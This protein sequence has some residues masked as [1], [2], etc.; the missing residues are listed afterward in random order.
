MVVLAAL[1]SSEAKEYGWEI[2]PRSMV[3]PAWER[4]GREESIPKRRT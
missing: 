2:A 3:L 1:E 4:R